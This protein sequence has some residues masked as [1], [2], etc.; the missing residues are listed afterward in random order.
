MMV[1]EEEG[2]AA[3]HEARMWIGAYTGKWGG[4][5]HG[6]GYQSSG[7]SQTEVEGIATRCTRQRHVLSCHRFS[8]ILIKITL[9]EIASTFHNF[10]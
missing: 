6:N 8:I 2:T 3:E 1:A 10:S 7:G 5:I 4:G 9:R